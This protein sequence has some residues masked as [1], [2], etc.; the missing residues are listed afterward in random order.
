M[1]NPTKRIKIKAEDEKSDAPITSHLM[2]ILRIS[3]LFA[4]DIKVK[5]NQDADSCADKIKQ[6][7]LEVF[8]HIGKSNFNER[9]PYHRQVALNNPKSFGKTVCAI[10]CLYESLYKFHRL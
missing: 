6:V 10:C 2:N 4:S 9:H 5:K 7:G 8:Y 1:K 3:G